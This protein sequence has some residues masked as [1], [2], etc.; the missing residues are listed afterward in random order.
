MKKGTILTIVLLA[1]LFCDSTIVLSAS[2]DKGFFGDT[3]FEVGTWMMELIPDEQIYPIYVADP[4][5]PRLHVGVGYIDTDIP[6]TSGGTVMLDAGTRI[7]LLKVQPASKAANEFSIDIEGGLFTQFDLLSGLDNIGWDGRYGAYVAWNRSDLVVARVGYRHISAHLGD[8]YMEKTGR[9]RINYT[10]ND[11]RIGV[12]YN[13]YKS[14]LVYVEPSYATHRG[15]QD[16][17]KKWAIEGGVQYQGP[18]DI[19]KGSTGLY[20]GLHISSYEENGWTP[21]YCGQVGLK[22]KRD[23]RMTKLRVGF[24][25]YIGRALLGEYALDFDEAYLTLGVFIDF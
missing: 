18:Y 11:L 13:L 16:R 21:S 6:D 8:E 1:V 15:N 7:T 24:E 19:W 23:P 10:R 12:G 25:G 14:T 22:I 3:T 5:R 2:E 20:A 4:R 9:R 17:Q